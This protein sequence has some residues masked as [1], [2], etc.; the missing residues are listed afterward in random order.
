MKDRPIE[1][2]YLRPQTV[3]EMCDVSV[4]LVY[5]DLRSGVLPARKMSSRIWLITPD[6]MERWVESKIAKVA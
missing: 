4:E 3:A 6:D 1:R 5:K 2:K